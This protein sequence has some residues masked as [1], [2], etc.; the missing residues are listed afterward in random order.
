MKKFFLIIFSLLL[1]ASAYHIPAR[2]ISP[3]PAAEE[4]TPT[5]KLDLEKIKELKDK[6]ASKVSELRQKKKILLSGK[7][8]TVKEDNITLT[9]DTG[10]KVVNFDKTTKYFWTKTSGTVMKINSGNLSEGDDFAVLAEGY[11]NEALSAIIMIGKINT[12]LI[13]GQIKSLNAVDKTFKIAIKDK[14]TELLISVTE[15]TDI[16][17]LSSGNDFKTGKFGNLAKGGKVLI[18]GNYANSKN[19]DIQ[20][21]RILIF[22]QNEAQNQ[23]N[24]ISPA[25]TTSKKK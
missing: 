19:Q 16:S 5:P 17:I 21:K 15:A 10:D 25:P 23:T 3:T 13:E 4:S 14:E 24:G 18:R 22:P 6:V 12:F 9:T 1:L 8:K 7:I 2:A 11:D 20:A